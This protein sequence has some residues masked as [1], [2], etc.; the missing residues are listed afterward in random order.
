MKSSALFHYVAAFTFGLTTIVCSTS[1]AK[2][3]ALDYNQPNDTTVVE[4]GNDDRIYDI[5]D[6]NAEF[7][8]GERANLEWLSNNVQYPTLALERGIQGRVVVQFIVNKDGSLSDLK[9]LQSPNELLSQEALRVVGQM[10]R[11]KPARQGNRIV[12]S[13]FN[14]PINFTIRDEQKSK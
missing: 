4:D 8:G 9:V 1:T 3:M 6:E 10:P 7:P 14:L 5:T 11:W 2:A 13:R 12:R